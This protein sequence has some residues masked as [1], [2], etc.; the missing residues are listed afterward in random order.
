MEIKLTGKRALVTG[1]NSGIG[2]VIALAL[3]DA[4]AKVAVNYVVNPEAAQAVAGKVRDK[5]GDTLA[6]E[7]DVGNAEQVAQMFEAIDFAWGG[8]DVLVNNAGIDGPRAYGWESD[9]TAWRRVI[10][11]N[12]LGAFHCS[13]EALRRMVAQTSGVILNLTSVHEAIP[14]SG[15]S[16]Y[17][18]AK[19]GASMLT[20]TLAQEAA[21][22]GVRVLAIAPGAIQTPINQAV[23]SDPQG[24]SD[25]IRKIP[26]GRLGQREE[27]AQMAVFLV[28]E[29]AS[30]VTGTTVFVDGGMTDYADFAHGG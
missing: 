27:I 28:S 16:A 14:W 19:A 8:L 4:G 26:I 25:L 15:Y 12:L 3:A 22:H 21:P 29:A 2:E 10:E 23:W 30:Y 17:T 6:L 24:L 18:A 9:P 7:A 20:R 5:T 13:R 11:I 1:A